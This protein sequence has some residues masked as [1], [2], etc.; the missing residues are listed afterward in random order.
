[1]KPIFL[2]SNK[3]CNWHGTIHAVHLQQSD[4]R[5]EM[6]CPRCDQ[7][8]TE[9]SEKQIGRL[10][11][12]IHFKPSEQN[13]LLIADMEVPERRGQ[14]GLYDHTDIIQFTFSNN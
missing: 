5:Y 4:D 10:Q 1:M 11:C 14:I 2:C 9:L 7:E 6:L 8:V 13:R 3:S 12:K